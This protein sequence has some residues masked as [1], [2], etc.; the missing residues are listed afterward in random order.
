MK[1][2]KIRCS[3]IGKIMGRSGLTETQLSTLA[4]LEKKGARTTKQEATYQELLYKKNNPELP[5]TC[6][7]F[8]EDWYKEQIY[9]RR[10]EFTSNMTEK[11]NINED[12]A[13][14]FIADKLNYPFLYKN[15]TYFEDDYMTGTPDMIPPNEILDSKCSWDCFTFPLLEKELPTKDYWWQGQGYMNLL[16]RKHFKLCY[17]LTDTPYHIIEREAR[18]WCFK[19]GYDELD[20][21]ILAQFEKKMTYKDIDDKY[22]LKVFCF[23][24][25]DNA[26]TQIKQRV[27]ECRNY[28]E[29]NFNT[30]EL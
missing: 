27:I 14:D 6:I 23:D 7:S 17:V 26:I 15:E 9:G 22:K 16:N 3:A 10:K 13:I 18:N 25:D 11:G 30:I 4:D 24:R 28:I 19:N 5:T 20:D 21:D 2:F 12:E 1:T 8:L 29:K